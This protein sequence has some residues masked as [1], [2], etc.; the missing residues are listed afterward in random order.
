MSGDKLI[1]K[2]KRPKGE[3][4]CRT[5]SVRIREEIVLRMDTI[6]ARTGRSRNELVGI[7]LEYALDH[8]ELEEDEQ[9][10]LL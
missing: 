7:F 3:D 6:A 5:F 1:V 8:C 4:G 2:S 10:A 9:Y